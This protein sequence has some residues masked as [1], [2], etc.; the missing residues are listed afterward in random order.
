[1]TKKDEKEV[2]KDIADKNWWKN[3]ESISGPGSTLNSTKYLRE[4]LVEVFTQ[5]EVKSIVDAP[6]GDM[7]W[8][9]H[10]GYP[11]EKYIGIDIVPEIVEKLRKEAW[12]HF[13]TFQTGNIV[14][15]ILPQADVLFCRDCLVHL[16]FMEGQNAMR[17]WKLAGF[18]YIITTT[19]PRWETNKDCGIG[20][21]RALNLQ[22]A[23]YF[24]P[25]P[26]MLI[27]EKSGVAPPYDD[28]SLGIWKL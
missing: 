11:F 20:G 26:F 4:K 17:L 18:K 2:F 21:W 19:F 10:L 28:K 7:N 3:Q 25:E 14:S 27:D 22:K 15:D 8:M 13:Y 9:R 16:P 23:P 24:L 6:C 1:M 5:L 12:P